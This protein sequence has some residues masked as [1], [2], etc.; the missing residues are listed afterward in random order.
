M[1][2]KIK[3]IA[4]NKK[5]R[6]D[7]AILETYEAGLV[8][9]GTEVKSLR[10][11][12]C[13]IKEAYVQIKDDE[14]WLMGATISLYSHGNMNNHEEQRSRKLL[15]HK[16]EIRKIETEV[17]TQRVSVIPTKIYFS[18]GKV[19]IEI[20]LG[21]GKRKYD[22]RQDEAKKSAEKKLRQGDY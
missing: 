21:K 17:K 15:L 2:T 7:Y 12:K 6:H 19:K 10:L 8:L 18:K 16:K 11:G 5:A 1:T 9:Q 4:N 20:G 22:K 13:S 14:A 3:I